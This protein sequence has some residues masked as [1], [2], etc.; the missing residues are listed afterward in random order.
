METEL[1]YGKVI[2]FNSKKGFGFIDWEKDGV[3]QKDM[4]VHFSD[5]KM[6]GYKT[7]YKDQKVS[8]SLGVNKHGDPKAIN[9][10]ILNH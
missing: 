1:Y 6:E 2:F 3:K 5:V 4:F 10:L 7:L 8:F 9:V